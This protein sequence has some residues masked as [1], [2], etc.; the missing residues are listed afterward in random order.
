MYV[1]VFVFPVTEKET[2][3]YAW[4]EKLAR[5]RFEKWYGFKPGLLLRRQPL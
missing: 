5:R 3:V 1:Y 4:S 2:F